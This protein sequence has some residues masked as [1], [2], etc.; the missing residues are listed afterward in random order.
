LP[1]NVRAKDQLPIAN[2]YPPL[3]FND[4]GILESFP[5]MCGDEGYRYTKKGKQGKKGCQGYVCCRKHKGCNASIVMDK[6]GRITRMWERWGKTNPHR[7]ECLNPPT[8]SDSKKGNQY[9][10][11][12]K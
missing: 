11:K 5:N 6:K 12:S 7:E 10:K 4:D 2:Y 1:G 8:T 3:K 9:A